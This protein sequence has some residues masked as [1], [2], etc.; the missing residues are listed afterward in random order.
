[1]KQG[2]RDTASFTAEFLH[3][4]KDAELTDKEAR[5]LLISALNSHVVAKV[6]SHFAGEKSGSASSPRTAEERL[7]YI[8]FD[9]ITALLT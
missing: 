4:M 5:G 3:W 9:A 8:S 6:D 7:S 1:M 2:D